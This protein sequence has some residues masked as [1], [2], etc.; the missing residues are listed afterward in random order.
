MPG[1]TLS[2]R[3]TKSILRFWNSLPR[4][5]AQWVFDAAKALGVGAGLEPDP[6]DIA[7][8]ELVHS[9]FPDGNIAARGGGGH[10]LQLALKN[11]PYALRVA[12]M[13]FR[14]DRAA[15]DQF[16]EN[17]LPNRPRFCDRAGCRGGRAWT[18]DASVSVD[19]NKLFCCA[20]CADEWARDQT[21]T[22]T[23]TTTTE[24]FEPFTGTAHRLDELN[25]DEMD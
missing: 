4:L 17:H 12:T 8:A 11:F 19:P 1:T 6:P 20:E 2:R 14:D 16:Y 25:L 21:T 23:T 18:T 24:T 9:R 5:H 22:T 10:G 15:F 7:F 3:E 13:K